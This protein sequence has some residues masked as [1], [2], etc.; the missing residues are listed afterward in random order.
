METRRERI[1]N[2]VTVTLVTVLIWIWAAGETREEITSFADL[3]FSG[4]TR[5]SLRIAPEE[6]PS[7]SFQIRG[8]RREVDA[9]ASRFRET[10]DIAVGTLGVPATPG[11]HEVDLVKL[12]QTF[13]DADELPVTVLAADPRTIRITI[14]SLERRAVPVTVELPDGVQTTNAVDV[15]PA[16]VE[17]LLPSDLASLPGLS[18]TA[19][20]DDAD[21]ASLPPGRRHELE[22]ALTL[23]DRLAGQSEAIRV[24]PRKARVGLDLVSTDASIQVPSIPVQVSGP[25]ADLDQHVVTIDPASVFLRDVTLR[26]P[27]A[28]IDDISNGRVNVIAFIHLT[29]D[30]L[31]NRI[32]ETRISMW[33]LPRGVEV[34]SIG[35]KPDTS[36]PISITIEDR[37]AQP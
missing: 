29:S 21:V 28:A 6:L 37:S 17:L 11:E 32:R 34:S 20:V 25:P 4:Q 1:T 15:V 27:R 30:D 8:P 24:T 26:G 10:V 13:V 5:D 36:P 9:V 18:V 12:G 7:V 16:E 19:R 14:E 3:R 2:L 33:R 22:I 35:E 23:P 31:A